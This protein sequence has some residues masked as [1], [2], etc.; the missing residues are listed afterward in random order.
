MLQVLRGRALPLGLFPAAPGDLLGSLHCGLHV[1]V[2]LPL[3]GSSQMQLSAVAPSRSTTP[4]SGWFSWTCSVWTRGF[5][6]GSPSP[7]KLKD[8]VNLEKFK[9]LTGEHCREMWKEVCDPYP[10]FLLHTMHMRLRQNR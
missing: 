3:A 5:A 10:V 9:T 1:A 4:T 2:S 7:T 8:I 6:T